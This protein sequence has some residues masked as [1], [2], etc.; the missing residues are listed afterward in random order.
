MTLFPID[1]YAKEVAPI[2]AFQKTETH[3]CTPRFYGVIHWGRAGVDHTIAGADV[4]F[5]FRGA[6]DSRQIEPCQ[7]IL[8][9]MAKEDRAPRGGMLCLPCG[10]G[11]TVC[12]L[13]V[14]S[15]MKKKSIILVHK[16]FLLEQWRERASQFCPGAK[17]GIIQQSTIDTEADIIIGMIQSIAMRTYDDSVF[18]DIG[19]VCIDE[20]HHMSAPIFNKALQKI[21]ARYVLSLSAT[22][23]RRDGMTKL[24]HWCMGDIIYRTER[25]AEE[26]LKI[27]CCVY[28]DRNEFKEFTSRDGRPALPQML[29]HICA[30]VKRN[31]W[32]AFDIK[33]L[34]ASNRKIIILSDRISQLDY[35]FDV[36]TRDG[37][38]P[39]RMTF[40]IGKT[41][42]NER[43]A[44]PTKEVIF[45]TYSMS[46]EALDIPS[47]DT[48]I[49]ASPTGNV[50]Q[51][52]GRILRKH[53]DKKVPLVLDYIDPFSIFESMRL[54]RAKYY[55]KMNYDCQTINYS[56]P[57]HFL[58]SFFS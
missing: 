28:D 11:K 14:L 31:L 35:L 41:K 38:A 46:R 9:E 16:N 17:I 8:A 40:Y 54:K 43:D 13:Y 36:L 32:I 23:D 18:K 21:P 19:M 51:A 15:K 3:F 52:F 42:K 10:F 45:S 26:I 30:N 5:D 27:S 33:R 4:N 58:T 49:M 53:P 24:L 25:S 44:A 7:K 22:P 50:E 39:D 1:P 47:L 56:S 2:H 55:K 29:N 48:L 20:S 12:A 6:L 34:L 37:I 57:N